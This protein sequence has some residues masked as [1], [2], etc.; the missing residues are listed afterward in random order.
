LGG[1]NQRLSGNAHVR[2][3]PE[4]FMETLSLITAIGAIAV[5]LKIL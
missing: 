5:P 3:F 1:G 2:F 4:L